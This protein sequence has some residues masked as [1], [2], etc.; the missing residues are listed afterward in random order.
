MAVEVRRL[1][2]RVMFRI[3]VLLS[4]LLALAPAGL[5]TAASAQPV[6]ATEKAQARV[7]LIYP[8][9]VTKKSDMDFG[10]LAAVGAGTAVLEPNSNSLSTTGGVSALGGDPTSAVFIG[11][12][13][14]ASVVNIKVPNQP[15]TLTRV[16][17]T[18]TMRVDNFT[19]QGQDK[20][21]LA[22]MSTFEFRVGG[23]LRVNAYQTEGFYSGTFDVTVH[24]P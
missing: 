20:R 16:G 17:G 11:A 13:Q 2:E 6:E 4:S 7:A 21:T 18:E 10:Y 23:T 3:S 9:T 24:Y 19:L 5:A 12:S 1:E 14:S 8:L 22:K 15:I